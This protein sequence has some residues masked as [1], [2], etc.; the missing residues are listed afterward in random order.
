MT[1]LGLERKEAA[2]LFGNRSIS[3]LYQE[4]LWAYQLLYRLS[5]AFPE[6]NPP[7][8]DLSALKFEIDSL[9][10]MVPPQYQKRIL[11]VY[12]ED[13]Q[14]LGL[15]LTYIAEKNK[16]A[17]AFTDRGVGKQLEEGKRQPQNELEALRFVSGYFARKHGR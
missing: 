4:T 7:N 3:V 10:K 8:F 15:L 9:W 1:E 17:K 14:K 2:H 16:N 12:A 6:V 11:S 13:T 5:I